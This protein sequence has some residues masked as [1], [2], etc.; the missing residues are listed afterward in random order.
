MRFSYLINILC[1]CQCAECTRFAHIGGG[2]GKG[3]SRK[4]GPVTHLTWPVT[5]T[6]I[7]GAVQFWVLPNHI[8]SDFS[9]PLNPPRFTSPISLPSARTASCTNRTQVALTK[10]H[11]YT[12]DE[13]SASIRT[14]AIKVTIDIFT[15][16]SR[17]RRY[18]WKRFSACPNTP[19][20][21]APR[22]L[23]MSR[24]V[25]TWGGGGGE[26][27]VTGGAGLRRIIFLEVG[28]RYNL[29]QICATHVRM[30]T[31]TLS[32]CTLNKLQ[33]Y[34]PNTSHSPRFLMRTFQFCALLQQFLEG[35]FGEAHFTPCPLALLFTFWVMLAAAL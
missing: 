24:Y 30:I 2:G 4:Y 27:S 20:A 35:I 13:R 23:L 1:S 29:P 10:L 6:D 32:V 21:P 19:P 26:L 31:C 28:K 22:I 8:V 12:R 5:I 11:H 3:R 33:V 15:L 17:I 7:T 9:V 14:V 18:Q 25:L 34:G 16:V